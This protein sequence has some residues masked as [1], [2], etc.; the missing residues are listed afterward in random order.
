MLAQ[1]AADN[2]ATYVDAYTPSIGHDACQLLTKWVEGFLP[3]LPT[4]PV[5]PNIFGIQATA[6]AVLASIGPPAS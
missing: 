5:H 3:T 6:A 2:G 4:A 1:T